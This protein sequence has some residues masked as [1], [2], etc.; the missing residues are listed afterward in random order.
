[1]SSLLTVK[2]HSSEE[3]GKYVVLLNSRRATSDGADRSAG[4][5][6]HHR[7]CK[8]LFQKG[9]RQIQKSTTVVKRWVS[10]QKRRA[11]AG[12]RS[13]VPA[14]ASRLTTGI[15]SNSPGTC[16]WLLH[17]AAS[18]LENCEAPLSSAAAGCPSHEGMSITKPKRL[19]H[20]EDEG[21]PS[22]TC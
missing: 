12:N 1:M 5:G 11:A 20:Q 10:R 2:K 14:A 6:T 18:Q 21:H 16:V 4:R 8:S 17:T 15:S 22:C 13:H 9:F 7:T 19:R 3:Y